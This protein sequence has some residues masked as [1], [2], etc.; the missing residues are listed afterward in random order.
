MRSIKLEF[1]ELVTKWRAAR[2]MN[3]TDLSEVAGVST[4][5][6]SFL[7]NGRADPSREMVGILADSFGLSNREKNALYLSAGY[8]AK[9]SE[10]AFDS[11]ALFEV[12]ASLQAFIDQQN[13]FPIS[14]HNRYWRVV[15]HNRALAVTLLHFL[16]AEKFRRAY[17]DLS[18]AK[19]LFDPEGMRP[20]VKNW[21]TL[22][23]RIVNRM[24][25]E[26]SLTTD[27]NMQ[28]ALNDILNQPDIPKRWARPLEEEEMGILSP[29][30]ISDQ[31][32]DLRFMFCTTT[33]NYAEDVTIQ[34][35]RIESYVPADLDTRMQLERLTNDPE[36]LAI[37]ADQMEVCSCR[38]FPSR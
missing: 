35:L 33:L 29:I 30:H 23:R 10:T 6:I 38:T 36:L 5:H 7:E 32:Y 2:K 34:E 1:G 4:R 13:P 19:L 37:V 9:Y 14:I 22:A 25:H 31:H 15:M 21:S 12:R 27:P 16:G 24:L 3:Q 18:M 20:Y 26:A 11:P 8:A 28:T 17:K